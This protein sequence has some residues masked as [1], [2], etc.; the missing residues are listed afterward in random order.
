M[1]LSV[2]V[3]VYIYLYIFFGEMSVQILYPFKKIKWFFLFIIKLPEFFL[4]SEYEMFITDFANH[5][6]QIRSCTLWFAFLFLSV[7]QRA[8]I[9]M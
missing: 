9:F 6:L 8:K 1:C 4:Y 3:S 2:H 7:F 5:I